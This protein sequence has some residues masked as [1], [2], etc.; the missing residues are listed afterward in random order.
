MDKKDY[1]LKLWS[2]V[3]S[4]STFFN[5]SIDEVGGLLEKD[6]SIDDGISKL[7][8]L[9]P[10]INKKELENDYTITELRTWDW[11]END[12]TITTAKGHES[13]TYFKI[14]DFDKSSD[15]K[16]L[17]EEAKELGKTDI[18]LNKIKDVPLC[19]L[20]DPKCK[21]PEND[22]RFNKILT[23]Y[24]LQD[25]LFYDFRYEDLK[26]YGDKMLVSQKFT[27]NPEPSKNEIES[28][29]TNAGYKLIDEKQGCWIT[30]IEDIVII[31]SDLLKKNCRII[32]NKLEV[33]DPIITIDYDENYHMF[34]KTLNNQLL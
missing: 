10:E 16:K 11:L 21:P 22:N 30:K 5:L 6:L 7:Q 31:V 19:K 29:M 2:Y 17:I 12:Y 34:L 3:Q 18:D 26:M 23:Y 1:D 13:T 20:T 9:F 4:D 14:G 33:F 15:F 24:I 25:Y 8:L 27:C 32:K 28:C